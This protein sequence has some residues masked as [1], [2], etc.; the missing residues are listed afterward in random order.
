MS[1]IDPIIEVEISLDPARFNHEYRP[2]NYVRITDPKSNYFKELGI[3]D[4]KGITGGLWVKHNDEEI[5]YHPY[6]YA[7][8][9]PPE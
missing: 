2:G 6:G 5:V 8:T 1:S 3:V 4:R 9:S 7:P